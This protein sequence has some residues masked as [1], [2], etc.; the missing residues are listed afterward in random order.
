MHKHP[1][2]KKS[3]NVTKFHEVVE[4]LDIFGI[5][6][7]GEGGPPI[8]R[9]GG[10]KV[11]SGFRCHHCSTVLGMVSSMQKHHQHHHKDVPTPKTW[12]H[13][14]MQRLSDRPGPSSSF[15]EV[16]P[17]PAIAIKSSPVNDL[18][19]NL[20]EEVSKILHVDIATLNNRSISPWLL[21]T[22][23]HRH[24]EGYETKELMKLVSFPKEMEFPGLYRLLLRYMENATG[25][26]AETS[27]LTLQRLNTSDPSKG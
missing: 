20:R 24:I 15:F 6:V 10:L 17:S 21:T 2:L 12:P 19:S 5:P 16:L 18:V 11:H 23:W 22:H 3:F 1:S 13:C 8:A 7:L 26:I 9:F 27:E 4:K 25:L 14:K